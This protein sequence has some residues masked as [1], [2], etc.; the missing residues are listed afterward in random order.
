MLTIF[1]GISILVWE[2]RTLD[3]IEIIEMVEWYVYHLNS[4]WQWYYSDQV[5][6]IVINFHLSF[7]IRKLFICFFHETINYHLI[8]NYYFM[9][10]QMEQRW[11]N[12]DQ[13]TNHLSLT[14]LLLSHLYAI[15][16]SKSSFAKHSLSIYYN[17]L[18]N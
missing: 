10:I 15:W 3:V 16:S 13:V 4:A 1:P 17:P 14:L 9:H 8:T 18:S 6:M 5:T 11:T 2:P 12:W 7:P